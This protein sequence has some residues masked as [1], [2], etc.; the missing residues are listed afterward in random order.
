[1][2]MMSSTPSRRC[3]QR[4]R[5]LSAGLAA[6]LALAGT[7][8]AQAQQVVFDPKNHLENALQAARQLESLANE[9]RSLAA[10]PYSHLAQNSQS[11]RDMADLARSVEGL[12]ATATELERQFE[13]LYAGELAGNADLE[14]LLRQGQGRSENARRTARDL[15]R[16]A[17]EL[18]RLGRG[19]DGRLSGALSASQSASGQTA[20]I[21][22]SN[23][24]L[25][26][27]A[28]D[29]AALRSIMLAQS[30]LLAEQAARQTA[31]QAAGD[32]ARRQAWSR[33]AVVPRPPAFDPFSRARD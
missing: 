10:S 18:E 25:A 17:A 14:A 19:R 29:L 15:A 22:S 1:M 26:V 20:A 21:Q 5:R 30:R 3:L 8:A 12:G 31:D 24:I 32:A 2:S 11:L 16:H 27:L 9:A 4:N 23:Q 28:E 6:L 33:E 7:H 13:S